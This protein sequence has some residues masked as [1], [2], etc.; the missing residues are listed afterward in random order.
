MRNRFLMQLIRF[1]L[2]LIPG[3][4]LYILLPIQAFADTQLPENIEVIID[5]EKTYTIHGLSLSY[6]NNE[7]VSLKDIC[8]A[9]K[10][11]EKEFDL[12][13]DKS[14]IAIKT[15]DA[16][17]EDADIAALFGAQPSYSDINPE[18]YLT[19]WS[20]SERSSYSSLSHSL[21][22]LTL[23]D[24]EKKYYTMLYSNNGEYDCFIGFI[25]LCLLLDIDA[26][27]D[28]EDVAHISTTTAMQPVNPALLEGYGYFQN[29]NSLLVGDATT[30]EIFYE[31]NSDKAYPIASTTKLMTYLLTKEAISNG[32]ISLND[33]VTVSSKAVA[34][35]KTADG[36]TPMKEGMRISVDELIKGALL[37][38][39]N[40]CCLTL[41]E[42]I[43]GDEASFVEL[44]KEKANQLNMNSAIFYNSNGLPIYTDDL[45]PAKLQ[46]HMNTRDMFTLC[47]T[48]LNNY[49]EVKQVTSLRKY[50]LEALN[51]EVKN[52]NA[53]LYNMNEVNGLKTGTTTKSGACLV[54]SLTVSDGQMDHDL[55]IVLLG[56]EGS[57]DRIRVAEL[58]A[59]Y[60]KDVVT[61]NAS[62]VIKDPSAGSESTAMNAEAIVNLIVNSALKNR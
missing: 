10:G 22:H 7:Y 40:E 37:P 5:E 8:L 11:T 32:Q 55:V 2:C 61:G 28:D 4:L 41:A 43:A 54:A 46:N 31:Y 57:Q 35:S 25:D 34:L 15:K 59:H 60:A 45:L 33:Y 30:Q 58:M 9:L 42:Y 47:S 52:T 12:K 36:V 39:S 51:L 38:S 1:G 16:Q 21:N 18:E 53:L 23:N 49:P 56:A 20:S 29:V 13:I 50:D 27:E 62:K 14:N 48:I 17:L 6:D 26:Y 3:V 19:G 44:M 24:D